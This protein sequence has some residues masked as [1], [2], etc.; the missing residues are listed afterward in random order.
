MSFE[1][2][3]EVGDDAVIPSIPSDFWLKGG[4]T[5]CLLACVFDKTNKE[6]GSNVA[7]LSPGQSRE[8]QR[9]NAAARNV[10]ERD[11]AQKA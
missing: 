7:A 4:K 1:D 8:M 11:T 3:L 10:L 9:N 2:S 5:R 6:I